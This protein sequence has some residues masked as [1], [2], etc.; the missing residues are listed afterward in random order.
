MAAHCSSQKCFFRER[1]P[2][3][4]LIDL[5]TINIYDSLLKQG[6]KVVQSD[7]K[8][9]VCVTEHMHV[10]VSLCVHMSAHMCWCTYIAPCAF[11]EQKGL[12][13]I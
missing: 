9:Q 4:D 11:L 3:G 10:Y 2:A 6:A 7:V 13:L 1:G 12:L 5:R 8:C